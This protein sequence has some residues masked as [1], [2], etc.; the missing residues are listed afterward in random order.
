M[1]L[2][3]I[4]TSDIHGC[5][6]PYDFIHAK[7]TTVSLSQVATFVN[8][9]RKEAPDSVVLLDGGD[10]L[11]GQPTCYLSNIHYYKEKNLAAR[12]YNYLNYDA[13]CL[14]NHDIET[15]HPV[16]DKWTRE[17]DC[18]VL[19]ANLM[20]KGTGETYFK[21]YTIIKKKASELPCWD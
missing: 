21:P 10:I 2:K 4:F 17:M 5:F 19:C 16:Y 11:Q 9:L 18:P 6:F 14:G 15:G 12:I 13:V 1:N 8:E 7:E 3:I 20:V